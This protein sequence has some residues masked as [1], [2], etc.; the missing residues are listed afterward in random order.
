MELTLESLGL[1]QEELQD[2]VVAKLC[3]GLMS[4]VCYGDED[5]EYRDDSPLAHKLRET[6][7]KKVDRAIQKMADERLVPNIGTEIEKLCL[8]KTNE[9]GE[10]KGETFTF[11]EYLVSRAEHYLREKVNFDG[12]SEAESRYSS[13]I[14]ATT[15]LAWMVNNHLH[16]N[17]ETAMKQALMDANK[18]IVGGIEEAIKIKLAELA[19]LM[20][21][22][23]EQKRK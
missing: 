4:S 10:K 11:I 16:Y 22:N 1:T 12:H 15:R 19:Q 9:W 13:W 17:I 3:E 23:L 8:Q 20:T 6:L 14:A 21:V 7:Q 2:R 18:T 5:G